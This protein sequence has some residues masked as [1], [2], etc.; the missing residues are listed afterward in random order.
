M[1]DNSLDSGGEAM[2][3]EIEIYI[4]KGSS[5][6]SVKLSLSFPSAILI[7]RASSATK[8]FVALKKS[9]ENSLICINIHFDTATHFM[10][11]RRVVPSLLIHQFMGN[12]RVLIESGSSLNLPPLVY[13]H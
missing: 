5:S 12:E 3:D 2:N 4:T 8:I 11:E 1:N 9:V 6:S 10:A 7:S 13:R